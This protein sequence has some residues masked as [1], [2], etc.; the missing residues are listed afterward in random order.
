MHPQHCEEITLNFAVKRILFKIIR[1][2]SSNDIVQTLQSC[3]LYF[4]FSYMSVL[5]TYSQD[6]QVP[7]EVHYV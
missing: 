5:L 6:E 3:Q 4:N 7:N 1:T 2:N